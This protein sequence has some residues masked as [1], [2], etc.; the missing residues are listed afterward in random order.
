MR[1]AR[2][3]SGVTG[4]RVSGLMGILRPY[5]NTLKNTLQLLPGSA[6]VLGL[7]AHWSCPLFFFDPR[8]RSAELAKFLASIIA[9]APVAPA[10]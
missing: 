5:K 9:E 4:K 1:A 2:G 10:A 7:H 3:F 8:P 6:Q